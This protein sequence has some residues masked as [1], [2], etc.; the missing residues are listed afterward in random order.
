MASGGSTVAFLTQGLR[1]A[2]L[3]LDFLLLAA[4]YLYALSKILWA[5]LFFSYQVVGKRM[6]VVKYASGILLIGCSSNCNTRITDASGYEIGADT[7]HFSTELYKDQV[8]RFPVATR[9]V[10]EEFV[11]RIPRLSGELFLSSALIDKGANADHFLIRYVLVPEGLVTEGSAG[12]GERF[13]SLDRAG[14]VTAY[15]TLDTCQTLCNGLWID[16]GVGSEVTTGDALGPS[17]RSLEEDSDS[18]KHRP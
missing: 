14:R 17:A 8:I 1:L 6:D 16:L 12:C 3:R 18:I 9:T 10:G 11:N 13:V 7:I 15:V 2:T 4:P 5:N